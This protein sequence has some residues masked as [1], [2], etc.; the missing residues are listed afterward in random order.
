MQ[1]ETE[2]EVIGPI[3]NIPS[4][5]KEFGLEQTNSYIQTILDLN[6]SELLYK[7]LDD[8]ILCFEAEIYFRYPIDGLALNIMKNGA[9]PS[10]N[11]G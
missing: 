7:S 4:M 9:T 1:G 2:E 8:I 3:K 6:D 11:T 10:A 5:L